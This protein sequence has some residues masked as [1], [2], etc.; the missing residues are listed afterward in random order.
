MQ[1]QKYLTRA[2]LDIVFEALLAHQ[3]I[4]ISNTL[5]HHVWSELVRPSPESSDPLSNM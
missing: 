5:A 4:W 3:D 1:W 2:E